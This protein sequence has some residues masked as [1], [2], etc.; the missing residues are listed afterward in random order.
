M[1]SGHTIILNTEHETWTLSHDI[2]LYRDEQAQ[3]YLDTTKGDA[4][5]QG[6]DKYNQIALQK[7]CTHLQQ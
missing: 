4:F 7:S 6:F 2:K 5:F 3:N 1:K